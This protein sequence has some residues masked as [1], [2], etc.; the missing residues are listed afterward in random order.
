MLHENT[1]K[2]YRV[3]LRGMTFS[4]SGPTYGTSYVVA[5]NTDEA[6]KKVYNFIKEK[7][8]GFDHERGLNMIELLA[9]DYE[10]TDT[11]T[12]LYL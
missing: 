4:S 9:E 11:G 1:Q 12:I 5:K 6:Y 7:D 2:L 3:T 8:L 10:Y